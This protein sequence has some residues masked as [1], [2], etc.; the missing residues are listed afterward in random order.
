MKIQKVVIQKKI[1][2]LTNFFFKYAKQKI[3]VISDQQ[4]EKQNKKQN[5]K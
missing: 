4:A 2:Y 1:Y 5:L 3:F